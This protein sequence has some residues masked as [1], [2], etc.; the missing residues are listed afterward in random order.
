MAAKRV[1]KNPMQITLH[2]A[3]DLKLVHERD[4]DHYHNW[5]CKGGFDEVKPE[6]VGE[7]VS[8]CD[9]CGLMVGSTLKAGW[10][11]YV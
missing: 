7:L 4:C 9:L 1:L 6:F 8:Q 11:T 10:S 5:N 3:L 2:E